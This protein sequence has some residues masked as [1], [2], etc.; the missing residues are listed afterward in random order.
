MCLGT[1]NKDENIN[2]TCHCSY[3]IPLVQNIMKEYLKQ[4]S[5]KKKNQGNK[6]SFRL[7]KNQF[8]KMPICFFSGNF[9]FM[10]DHVPGPL[11]EKN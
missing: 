11:V 5:F 1:K 8:S 7:K 9:K 2:V 6:N 4:F 10:C 3:M